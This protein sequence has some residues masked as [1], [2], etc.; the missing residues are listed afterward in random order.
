MVMSLY[1]KKFLLD[2][3][4][5]VGDDFIDNRHRRNKR[6]TV[7]IGDFLSGGYSHCSGRLEAASWELSSAAHRH[8]STHYQRWG[9]HGVHGTSSGASSVSIECDR[10]VFS[11]T[12]WHCS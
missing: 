5:L 12:L 10:V 3:A 6:V 1:F 4:L 11:I 2:N 9:F 7:S 8:P